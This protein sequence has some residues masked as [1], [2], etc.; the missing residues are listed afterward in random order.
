[1]R[2]KCVRRR[3]LMLVGVLGGALVVVGSAQAELT[4][5]PVKN[6]P[7][8]NEVYG[9]A[10]DTWLV[11]TRNSIAHPRDYALYSQLLGGGPVVRVNPERTRG[12]PG[13]IEGN[14]LIYQQVNRG[15][16]DIRMYDLGTQTR[17][18]PPTGI[19]TAEWEYHVSMTPDWI[20]FGRS[21]HG[22]DRVML[23]D[24]AAQTLKQIGS[25]EWNKA[26][27][28]GIGQTD[29]SGQYAAWTRCTGFSSCQVKRR[30]LTTRQTVTVP[31]KIGKVDY[32][33][34]VGS[35]GTVFYARSGPQC[36]AN[37]RLRSYS[38]G[39]VDS[40]LVA[41]KP[42]VEVWSSTTYSGTTSDDHYYSKFNCSR[43]QYDLFKAS[44]PRLT[45]APSVLSVSPAEHVGVADSASRP[46]A[47]MA[48]AINNPR[49]NRRTPRG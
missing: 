40:L 41:F 34:S 36:G 19:N 31:E 38:L 10:S 39:G 30:D 42:G 13:S 12:Y 27:T 29:V 25:V 7:F 32:S 45:S 5:V 6:S 47:R 17:S 46:A 37:A 44:S 14:S 1:M 15:Q 11:F 23:Y 2:W 24:R 33:A 21:G 22:S 9:A 28:A 48:M 35:D 18:L 3:A 43:H 16:S 49:A 8:V 20:V 4:Q 26:G